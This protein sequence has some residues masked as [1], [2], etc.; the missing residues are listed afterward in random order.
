LPYNKPPA[1]PPAAPAAAPPHATLASFQAV[2]SF[3]SAQKIVP[4]VGKSG[5]DAAKASVVRVICVRK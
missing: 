4:A 1:F 5:I 2:R 3:L